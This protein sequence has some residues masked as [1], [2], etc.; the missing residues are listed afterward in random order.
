MRVFA[1]G[2]SKK[3]PAELTGR[4]EGDEVVVFSGG[5][6]LGEGFVTVEITGASGVALFGK[7]VE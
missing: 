1:E 4:T 7:L 6:G 5:E 3:N 2:P